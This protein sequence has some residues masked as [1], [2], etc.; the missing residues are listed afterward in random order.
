MST[1]NISFSIKKQRKSPYVIVNLQLWD[2]PKGL[3]YESE[4][5]MVNEPS[6]FEPLMVYCMCNNCM[7][8]ELVALNL[9]QTNL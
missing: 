8:Y 5:C 1:H 3:K 2:F 9:R 4:T 6:V 7:N